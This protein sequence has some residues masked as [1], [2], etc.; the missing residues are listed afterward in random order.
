MTADRIIDFPIRPFPCR[1]NRQPQGS[2]LAPAG[3][4]PLSPATAGLVPP[5]TSPAPS[6]PPPASAIDEIVSAWLA[7]LS[8]AS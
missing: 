2:A 8:E 3:V 4:Y 6:N 1:A 5:S 7:T